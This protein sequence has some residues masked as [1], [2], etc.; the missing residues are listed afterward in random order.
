MLNANELVAFFVIPI[1]LLLIQ[2]TILGVLIYKY[3][4]SDQQ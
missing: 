2:L 1:I 3:N 4:K